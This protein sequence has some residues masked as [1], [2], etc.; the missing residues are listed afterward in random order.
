MAG[1]RSLSRSA[2]IARNAFCSSLTRADAGMAQLM[3]TL[4]KQERSCAQ[5]GELIAD[6]L[7]AG[8]TSLLSEFQKRSDQFGV[9]AEAIVREVAFLE[10]FITERAVNRM[11]SHRSFQHA[12]LQAC[13]RR[14][15]SRSGVLPGG[16]SF[17]DDYDSRWDTYNLFWRE[18]LDSSAGMALAGQVVSFSGAAT[19][20]ELLMYLVQRVATSYTQL[21]E[22]LRDYQKKLRLIL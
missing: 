11:I 20:Y 19:H 15:V 7:D 14:V 8:F 17:Q 9:T 2:V 13:V 22:L 16:Q 12:V 21:L 1:Y 5:L 4:F 18:P 10:L 6:G 3:L